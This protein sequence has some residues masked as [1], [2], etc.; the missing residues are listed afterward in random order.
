MAW[1]R[2]WPALALLMGWQI[3]LVASDT[4]MSAATGK[5]YQG[6]VTLRDNA[7]GQSLIQ[8]E[9]SGTGTAKGVCFSAAGATDCGLLSVDSAGAV[10]SAGTVTGATVTDGT[11]SVTSGAVTGVTTITT[12]GD[13][14]VGGALSK[15]SGT[16][17][18]VHPLD[19]LAAEGVRLRHSFVEAPRADNLYTGRV[20]L[21]AAAASSVDLDTSF[22][23]TRGT[24]AALNNIGGARVLATG[25]GCVVRWALEGANLVLTGD[26][27]GAKP[28]MCGENDEV[29]FQVVA[30]RRDAAIRDSGFMDAAGEFVP[31]YVRNATR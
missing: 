1:L 27:T 19:E 26:A 28:W 22:R 10:T 5:Y 8:M 11:F 25:N 2:C 16:F 13:V 14:T 17:D 31:E 9:Y 20:I 15:G 30:E 12:T 6:Y 7:D 29:T 18:I 23:M 3:A 21:D 4:A 24:F